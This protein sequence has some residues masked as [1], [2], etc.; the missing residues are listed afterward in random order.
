M[1]GVFTVAE[2]IRYLSDILGEDVVLS[3][4]WIR[5][6]VS[7]PSLSSAGHQYFTMKDAESEIQCVIFRT[8][9]RGRLP[10]IRQGDHVV[11][12]GRL[13]VYEAKGKVQLYVDLV[14]QEG[15][16]PLHQQFEA[17]CARLRD[18]GLF[19]IERKRLLPVLPRRVG[20]VTSPQAAAYQDVLRVLSARFPAIEVVLSPTLVQGED[21]PTQIVA[22]IARLAAEPGIDVILLVRGG[23]SLEDLWAFN[24]ELVAR[25]IA[26]SPIPIVSG[27]GHETDTTIADFAADLRAPTPSAAAGAVVPDR[28]ELLSQI[29]AL[30]EDLGDTMRADLTERRNALRRARLDLDLNSPVRAIDQR[31]QR[32]DELVDLGRD[33]LRHHLE[34]Q[35][36]RRRGAESQL[37]LLNPLRILDRGFALV[38]QVEGR[39]VR[40][41][42]TLRPQEPVTIRFRDGEVSATITTGARAAQPEK[43]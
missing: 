8:R 16:G 36:E 18:E 29:A 27:V 30:S 1:D 17:L 22:A 4:L 13:G 38:T 34:L 35:H 39:I 43:G 3:G 28:L 6:E 21:A 20:V 25:A 24:S 42:H 40:D 33:R 14:Q 37:L 31:R 41:A 2:V 32:I 15:I 12:H 9:G 10:T 19:D 11:A 7:N 5:G 26:A 23:G